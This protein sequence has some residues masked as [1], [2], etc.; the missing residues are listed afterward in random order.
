VFVA[1]GPVSILPYE[2][3]NSNMATMVAAVCCC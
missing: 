3:K 1:V 2:L